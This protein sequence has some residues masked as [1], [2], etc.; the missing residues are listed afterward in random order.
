MVEDGVSLPDSIFEGS[1]QTIFLLIV[2]PPT[3]ILPY[4]GEESVNPPS[5]PSESITK[6]SV[7]HNKS[8]SP[9]ANGSG[10]EE[11]VA[12]TPKDPS[13]YKQYKSNTMDKKER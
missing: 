3:T 7:S 2:K 13:Y 12:E 8:S 1:L 10:F 5:I 9:K 11:K 6:T 4:L